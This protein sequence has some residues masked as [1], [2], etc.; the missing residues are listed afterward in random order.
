[1]LLLIKFEVLSEHTGLP[2]GY[3]GTRFQKKSALFTNLQQIREEFVSIRTQVL[4]VWN[5]I[6]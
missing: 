5:S 1:M 6:I 3:L 2:D 4:V